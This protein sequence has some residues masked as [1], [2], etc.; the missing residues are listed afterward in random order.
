MIHANQRWYS[1]SDS[2][3]AFVEWSDLVLKTSVVLLVSKWTSCCMFHF[4]LGVRWI[5]SLF[6]HWLVTTYGCF[7]ADIFRPN[8]IVGKGYDD[9]KV[10]LFAL[11]CEKVKLRWRRTLFLETNVREIRV[12][13]YLS[14]IEQC[15]VWTEHYSV[16]S[17]MFT[18]PGFL[19]ARSRPNHAAN[20]LGWDV[21]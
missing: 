4:F 5:M 17:P 14:T 7:L 2:G 6:V 15:Y 16:F 3:E 18:V 8:F 19:E 12:V 1:K 11:V 9:V 13:S 10:L 21:P 20:L